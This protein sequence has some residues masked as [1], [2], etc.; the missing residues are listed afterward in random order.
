[1]TESKPEVSRRIL[2]LEDN[3]ARIAGFREALAGYYAL[4]VANSVEDALRLLSGRHYDLVF[5]D[6]DL[7][8]GRRVYIDPYE[9]NTGYQVVKYLA[10]EPEYADTPIVVHSH[11][12]FGANKMVKALPCAV[13]VPFGIYPIGEIARLF[14]EQGL[15][16]RMK[17]LGRILGSG[18]TQ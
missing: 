8:F 6:H 2:V 4:D 1:M 14:L 11:N 12:W 9:E 13:Y 15:N 5:L 10:Q 18:L 7:D 16:P 3:S 17:D